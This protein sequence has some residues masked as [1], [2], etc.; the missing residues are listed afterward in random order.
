MQLDATIIDD[1][2]TSLVTLDEDVLWIR[3][4][5]RTHAKAAL[6]Q[7]M[8]GLFRRLTSKQFQRESVKHTLR[9][10][11]CNF[12]KM[13]KCEYLHE[14]PLVERVDSHI[15]L[16]QNIITSTTLLDDS[17]PFDVEDATYISFGHVKAFRRR[18]R[19][20]LLKMA[21]EL[22]EKDV[23]NGLIHLQYVIDK[24]KEYENNN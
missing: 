24:L 22:L 12:D 14:N 8:Y 11:T 17:P 5:L 9:V 10:A 2:T 19:K 15:L 21:I 13:R 16:C 6:D 20:A 4:Q 23:D 3:T 7:K 18:D 1:I